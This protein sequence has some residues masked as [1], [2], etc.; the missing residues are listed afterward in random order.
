MTQGSIQFINAS[1]RTMLNAYAHL[2][3]AQLDVDPRVRVS[4][5]MFGFTNTQALSRAE[6]VRLV[7]RVLEQQGDIAARRVERVPLE[8]Q[9]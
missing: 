4:Q 1:L 7:A 3:D 6:A 8:K 9:P 2:A 5:A